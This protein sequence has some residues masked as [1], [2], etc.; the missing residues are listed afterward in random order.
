MRSYYRLIAVAPMASFE[1]EPI[2]LFG[3]T[4]KVCAFSY[5]LAF[6]S[7]STAGK[8]ALVQSPKVSRL[9]LNTVESERGRELFGFGKAFIVR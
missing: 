6:S 5:V 2:E 8:A 3:Y 7:T 1:R 4:K 9:T